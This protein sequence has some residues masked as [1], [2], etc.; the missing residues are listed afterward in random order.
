M[1]PAVSSVYAAITPVKNGT[2]AVAYYEGT[3]ADSNTAQDWYAAMA[4]VTGADTAHP[5]VTHRS[6]VLAKPVHTKDICLDGI[7]CGLPGFGDDRNLLDYVTVAVGPDGSL[8]GAFASDGPATGSS[9]RA[10][11]VLIRAAIPKK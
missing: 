6:H 11:T 2:L 8:W 5:V 9:S 10:S 1:T 4:V 7:V 3:K